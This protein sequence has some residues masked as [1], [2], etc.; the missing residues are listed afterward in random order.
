MIRVA[1]A[2]PV[3]QTG[4][5]TR[6]QLIDRVAEKL[7][8]ERGAAERAVRLVFDGMAQALR[9]GD[10]IE[11]RGF[12]SFKVR[13]YSGYRGRNPRSGESVEVRPK[14]SPIFKVGR[15]FRV[16]IA[17]G[18]RAAPLARPLANAADPE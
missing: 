7:G 10:P 5:M 16:K 12:G 1:R 9:R 11:L 8:L 18:A 14:R 13:A 3:D 6:S 15:P 2:A 4:G 17:S